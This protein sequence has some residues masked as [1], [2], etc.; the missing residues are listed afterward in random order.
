MVG[1]KEGLKFDGRRDDGLV[2][3]VVTQ[4]RILY[5]TRSGCVSLL[6]MPLFS[7]IDW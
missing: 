7:Y 3:S 6:A 4:S 2:I 5:R 1:R